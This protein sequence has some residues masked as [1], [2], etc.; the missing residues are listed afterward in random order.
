MEQSIANCTYILLICSENY[1]VK[2]DA[3]IGGVG[4]ETGIFANLILTATQIESKGA[5]RLIPVARQACSPII[6]PSFVAGRYYANLSANAANTNRDYEELVRRLHQTPL[7]TPPP[8]GTNPYSQPSM[9]SSAETF[10]SPIGVDTNTLRRALRERRTA[11]AARLVEQYP[12]L[13]I[14]GTPEQRRGELQI[15]VETHSDYLRVLS[16]A[17]SEPT[18]TSDLI[19]EEI[20]QAVAPRGWPHGGF[21]RLAELPLALGWAINRL[22]GASLLEQGRAGKAV[23]I[24]LKSIDIG[25]DAQ[26]PLILV[27]KFTGWP[28]Y[29]GDSNEAWTFS[30]GLGQSLPWISV[31]F[32]DAEEYWVAM[33]AHAM[34]LNF[35]EFRWRLQHGPPFDVVRQDRQSGPNVPL[36]FWLE[37]SDLQRRAFRLLMRDRAQ[38]R[39]ALGH[40]SQTLDLGRHWDTWIQFQQSWLSIETL[41]AATGSPPHGN[42]IEVLMSPE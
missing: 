21:Q 3:R 41:G 29:L 32:G 24:A 14:P 38:M 8:L 13:A 33:I 26:H 5:N 20:E 15:L 10:F 25:G 22:V 35:A 2:A 34:A 18:L 1:V 31:V 39:L 23:R 9:P 42:L 7:Y 4:Y 6:L 12:N 11:S 27:R 28:I 40:Y 19:I 37:A 30:K 17:A 36:Y 16:V